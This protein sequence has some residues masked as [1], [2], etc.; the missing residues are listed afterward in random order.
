MSGIT[1][2]NPVVN[3]VPTAIAIGRKGVD[4]NGR[5]LSTG[6]KADNDV[7]SSFLGQ[8]LGD[9]AKILT[10]VLG[11]MGYSTNAL[12]ITQDSLGSI[13][14]TLGDMLSVI[15]QNGGSKAATRT[16]DDILQQKLETIKQQIGSAEFDGRKLLTGDLG[17]DPTVRS[18]F[19]TK[20]VNVRGNLL[21]A[22][23]TF[24]ALG[25]SAS[26]SINISNN[27]NI[28]TGP[29]GDSITVGTITFKFVDASPDYDKNEILKGGTM[30]QTAQNIATSIRN[31]QDESIRAYGV[32]VYGTSVVVSK[33]TPGEG[34]TLL[35]N[36]N[37]GGMVTALPN[38]QTL[39]LSAA[40][41][42]VGDT[43]TIAGVTFTYAAAAGAS[44]ATTGVVAIGA[45]AKDSTD[46]LLAAIQA[47]PVTKDLIA[48]GLLRATS[49]SDGAAN[50]KQRITIQS[51]GSKTD[52]NFTATFAA[53]GIVSQLVDGASQTVTV[54]VAAAANGATFILDGT[55]L[56]F[57]NGGAAGIAANGSPNRGANQAQSVQ[58]LALAINAHAV[59]SQKFTASHDGAGVLTIVSKNGAFVAPSTGTLANAVYD[60]TVA[61]A[62][63][64]VAAT[65]WTAKAGGI[66][67]SGIKNV[68]GFINSLTPPPTFTVTSQALS[69]DVAN[70]GV[71]GDNAARNLYFNLKGVNPPAVVAGFVD[72][73]TAVALTATIAGRSFQAVVFKYNGGFNSPVIE[74]VEKSTGESFSV[75][76]DA[77]FNPDLT[78][79]AN[80]GTFLATPLTALFTSATFA[81]TRDLAIN[82]DAGDIVVNGASVASVAGMTVS[83]NSTSFANKE[84]KSFVITGASTGLPGLVKMTATI[85]G[86]NFVVD[87][88]AA[89]SLVKG[90]A[91]SLIQEGGGVDKL[92]INL[93]EKGLA[94]LTDIAN[95]A[96]VGAAIQAALTSSGSGLD[97]RVGLSFDDVLKVKVPDVSI[98]RLFLDNAGIYQDKLSVLDQAGANKAQEVVTN[99]L[100]AVRS[101]QA[102]VQ[103][104]SETVAAASTSL[105]SAIGVTK[106][107]SA[108][109]LDTD[110]VQA[111][112]AFAASL[113]SILAAISTL[114]AGARVADAGLEIIKSAAQ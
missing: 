93:G 18:K 35:A 83:L 14:A 87:N 78:T 61:G 47:H 10:K 111:A 44:T 59:L 29:G 110:L 84:F 27:A 63:N 67:L 24:T 19:D 55:T 94:S 112:S 80:A 7:V 11:N 57:N 52:I 2:K 39:E 48:R 73:D 104:Q 45:D 70:G 106:D 68:E 71:L 100:N 91:I 101:A 105:S 95:Y 43:V 15:A 26:S 102:R 86:V 72:G 96:P 76:T 85:S 113:K 16:L 75:P 69:G 28:T 81:Q 90:S 32:D 46:N 40:V 77:A 107:A 31:N 98:T 64:L 41:A 25:T 34:I 8:G 89:A 56:T 74:F 21:V 13:A 97:V 60:G 92:T 3:S 4:D 114:Q 1:L 12:R 53:G 79:V 5:S 99:A 66:N 54:T 9:K 17:S 38:T 58:S 20:I 103:G 109:Y 88:L 62:T 23:N 51:F 6:L 37:L 82:T 108:G 42:A 22:P 49:A 36:S 50:A 33:R 30:Q 65:Q